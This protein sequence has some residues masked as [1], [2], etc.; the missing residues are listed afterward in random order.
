MITRKTVLDLRTIAAA[1]GSLEVDGTR[2]TAL[3][4]RTIAAAGKNHGAKLIVHEADRF[5][6]L[7][8]R[9]VAAASPGNVTF[10]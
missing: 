2:Y 6:A 4:L 7:D 1:G 10:K 9:T 5:T 8:L 3:D